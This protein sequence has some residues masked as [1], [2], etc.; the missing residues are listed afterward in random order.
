M[1][2]YS[3]RP[4]NT[5]SKVLLVI[6]CQRSGTSLLASMLGRHSEINMLYESNTRDCLSMI[7]K[8]YNGNKVLAY[9]QIRWS[10]RATRFGHVVNRVANLALSRS[11]YQR[12]RPFP[13]SSLCIVD[14]LRHDA[15]LIAITRDKADVIRSITRRSSMT[16]RQAEREYERSKTIIDNLGLLAIRLTYEELVTSPEHI[17]IRLCN[18]LD[19]P[20]EPR[21]LEG[22]EY[23]YPYPHERF[24]ARESVPR[25]EA[26][27][28]GRRVVIR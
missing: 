1:A 13:T 18:E 7:G 4:M 22:P 27:E 24:T 17:M 6:G 28:S 11:K 15:R 5:L 12:L 21:M 16:R 26:A 2:C 25:T 10:Q 8:K 20:Y 23:N 19:L 9:R 3:W 14:Y